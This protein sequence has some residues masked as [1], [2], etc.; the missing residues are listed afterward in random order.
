[1]KKEVEIG[2]EAAER[3]EVIDGETVFAELEEDIR[4]IEMEMQQASETSS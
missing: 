2:I 3:G 4:Q 1:M